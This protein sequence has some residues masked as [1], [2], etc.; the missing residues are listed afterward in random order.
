MEGDSGCNES[1]RDDEEG[2]TGRGDR[3]VDGG[4]GRGC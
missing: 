4:G 2:A 1:D 3:V